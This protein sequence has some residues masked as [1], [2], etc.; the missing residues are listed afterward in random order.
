MLISGIKNSIDKLTGDK[1]KNTFLE[2]QINVA[3]YGKKRIDYKAKKRQF[4]KGFSFIKKML[5]AK[6]K[7]SS[8]IRANF[9]TA[10]IFTTTSFLKLKKSKFVPDI[11]NPK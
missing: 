7:D 2:R 3:K 5:I 6:I 8:R 10:G 1:I 4:N 9:N 11:L